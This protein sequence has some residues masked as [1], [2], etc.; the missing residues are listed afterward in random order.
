[1]AER[2]RTTEVRQTLHG[3]GITFVARVVTY[4]KDRN[5]GTLEA[6]IL[7]EDNVHGP[8]STAVFDT[9]EQG[10]TSVTVGI[11]EGSVQFDATASFATGD[12]APVSGALAA[13]VDEPLGTLSL[14]LRVEPVTP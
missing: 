7:W 12:G 6:L 3:Y 14:V 11:E 13:I 5:V 1:M 2:S 4:A 9:T 10:Q 8:S